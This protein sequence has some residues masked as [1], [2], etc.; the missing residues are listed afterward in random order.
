[1]DWEKA[2][3][4]LARAVESADRLQA[5]VDELVEAAADNTDQSPQQR[6]LLD[7]LNKVAI[8]LV[9]VRHGLGVCGRLA[10]KQAEKVRSAPFCACGRKLDECDGSRAGCEWVQAARGKR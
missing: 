7:N 4:T 2:E 9:M 10:H 1:M 5:Q 3:E 8:D 6:V